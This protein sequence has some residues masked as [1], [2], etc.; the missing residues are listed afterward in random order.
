MTTGVSLKYD[1]PSR[2]GFSEPST[3]ARIVDVVT[4]ALVPGQRLVLWG[5]QGTWWTR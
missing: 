3:R 4:A 2:F 1:L 5:T